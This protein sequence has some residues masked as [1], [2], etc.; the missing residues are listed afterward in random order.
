MNPC[1]VHSAIDGQARYLAHQIK[2]FGKK[3][4]GLC[5]YNAGPG[6]VLKYNG[7]PPYRETTRYLELILRKETELNAQ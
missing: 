7:C 6:A 2:V 3:E 5:A 4:W 1:D